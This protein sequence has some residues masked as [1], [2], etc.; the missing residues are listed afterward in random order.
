M[1]TALQVEAQHDAG[2]APRPA[3]SSPSL[4]GK[5]FGTANRQTISA[6]SDDAQAIFHVEKYIA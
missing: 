2:A 6:V 1:R 3:R 4:S 5:K